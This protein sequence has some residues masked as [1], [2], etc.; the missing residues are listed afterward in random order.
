MIFDTFK[1]MRLLTAYH[2]TWKCGESCQSHSLHLTR[3]VGRLS[4]S[5]GEIYKK[6]TSTRRNL[7]FPDKLNSRNLSVEFFEFHCFISLPQSAEL[8]A[9][10]SDGARRPEKFKLYIHNLLYKC[11]CLSIVF[12]S[13]YLSTEI[14]TIL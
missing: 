1:Y 4:D 9:P 6:A 10:S 11:R 8:T 12:E 3:E 14:C 5:E 2:K 7:Q 13:L